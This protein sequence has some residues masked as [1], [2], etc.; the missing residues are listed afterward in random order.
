MPRLP[1]APRRIVAIDLALIGDLV[2]LT[3]ALR[4]LMQ[5]YPAAELS[6]VAASNASSVL[7]RFPGLERVIAVNKEAIH[8]SLGAQRQ[9]AAALRQYRFDLAIL[10]HSSFVSALI[11]FLARIPQRAGYSKDLRDPLLTLRVAP[12]RPRQFH[13]VDQRLHLLRRLGLA[14][15]ITPPVY[16]VDEA[17]ARRTTERLLPGVPPTLPVV[18]MV[19]GAS[20]PT[21]PWP[22]ERLAAL[23]RKLPKQGCAVVLLGG[24]GQ[25]DA[26]A[27][28]GADGVPVHNLVGRTNL[29]ELGHLLWRADAVVTPD[30]G[31][32]HMAAGM[33]K[34]VIALFGPTDPRLC[35]MRHP[36]GVHL[37]PPAP[38]RCAW[39]KRCTAESFCMN[40]IT[41][42]AVLKRLLPVL[43]PRAAA[44]TGDA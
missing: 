27:G 35:G 29:D 8:R 37:T 13:L 39:R 14:T 21:K 11:A 42:D 9:A 16:R 44:R 26:A 10:F 31:P 28:I 6:V 1:A 19:V 22:P 38:C 30:S 2:C 43:A 4:C 12:P 18:A 20:W 41:E 5:A 36:A 15:Q 25:E 33:G 3:P 24:P 32:M 7:S 40:E 23:C 17:A 34:P